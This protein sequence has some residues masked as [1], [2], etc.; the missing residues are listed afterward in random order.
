[1]TEKHQTEIVQRIIK[2]LLDV[3]LL[4][5]VQA[6]PLWGYKI[7]KKVEADGLQ[8]VPRLKNRHFMA[9][10]ELLN[11]Q[12]REKILGITPDMYIE[13][14]LRDRDGT[15]GEIW[16]FSIELAGSTVYVKLKLD[17]NEAKCISFHD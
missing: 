14:P 11:Y 4:R 1:M 16:V 2:N 12:V 3:Q 6:Q 7:K 13:G 17:R 5:M 8:I 10:H 15:G 9:Y